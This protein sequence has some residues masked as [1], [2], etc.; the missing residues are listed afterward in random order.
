M[1]AISPG[2]MGNALIL[3]AIVAVVVTV[4]LSRGRNAAAK[5]EDEEAGP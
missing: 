2:A 4:W 3:G 5:A 1:L